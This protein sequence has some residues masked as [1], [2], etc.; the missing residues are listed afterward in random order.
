MIEPLKTDEICRLLSEMNSH[1]LAVDLL[2]RVFN[3]VINLIPRHEWK[4]DRELLIEFSR[5]LASNLVIAHYAGLGLNEVNRNPEL[6]LAETSIKYQDPQLKNHILEVIRRT[7]WP[8]QLKA[9]EEGVKVSPYLLAELMAAIHEVTVYGELEIHSSS[10]EG[11]LL[12]R[13][14]KN[15]VKKQRGAFYTPVKVAEFICENT[16]GRLLDEGIKRLLGLLEQ[17]L[18]MQTDQALSEILVE[19]EKLLDVKIVDPACGPGVFLIESLKVA[20]SR[21]PQ[22]R[23]IYQRLRE[24]IPASSRDLLRKYDLVLKDESNFLKHLQGSIYG[25]DLDPAAVEV[26][27]ISLSFITGTQPKH[28]LWVNLKR[29]NS[30]ISEFPPRSVTPSSGDLSYLLELREQLAKNNS[31]EERN[32]ILRLYRER[33]NLIQKH[34]TAP[35]GIKPASYFF[36]DIERKE[37]FCWELEFPE[38]FFR[39]KGAADESGGFDVLVMNPPYGI[40]K[41]NQ[42]R[43]SNIRSD[44]IKAELKKE[45]EFFRESGHYRLTEGVQNYYKLMVERALYLTSAKAYLGFIIPST[46]CCDR[47]TRKLRKEIL[48][49]YEILGIYDFPERA[50]VFLHVNQAVCIVLLNKARRGNII[51]LASGLGSLRELDYAN[52]YCIPLALIR[53]LSRDLRIPRVEK[54]AW[55]ILEKIHQV[56][57]LSAIGW[58]QNRRGEVD[59]TFY[60]DYITSDNTGYRLV[61]GNHIGRYVLRWSASEKESFVQGRI[62][63]EIGMRKIRDVGRTRIAGQQVSNMMQRWRL[64]FCLIPP[65]VFLGNSCNYLVIEGKGESGSTIL[66]LLALLNS[67]LLNWRFK[68]TSSNNHVSNYE[69]DSLPIKLIDKNNPKEVALFKFV[70]ENVRKVLRERKP[71]GIV[72]EIEAAVFRLYG[73]EPEEAV[74]ILKSEGA[75]QNE[76]EDIIRAFHKLGDGNER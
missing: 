54:W 23:Q 39:R 30:L 14:D 41:L 13:W 72:P 16:L 17:F 8:R 10:R 70:V 35:K 58:I 44:G 2:H 57:P 6:G 55:P 7:D 3:E 62:V 59:L 31:T 50:K 42:P 36:E 71:V 43:G 51:P 38:V 34:R 15:D 33:I 27:S 1:E 56:P 63:K 47:S 49:N 73:I 65:K 18:N 32:K 11:P 28:S 60:R 45:S 37:A 5:I 53:R 52:P 20:R 40:L 75:G 22:L 24:N 76:I 4:D 9:F 67:C 21:Y 61:R 69:L 12:L 64:K 68:L 26:A 46:F 66:Y 74:Y 48:L 19:L 25:V 29:G